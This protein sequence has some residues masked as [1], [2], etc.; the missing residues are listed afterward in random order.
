MR[1]TSFLL[2]TGIFLGAPVWLLNS[3]VMPELNDMRYTYSH[4]D[5]VAAK[6]VEE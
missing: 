3:V 6:A 4:L 1:I 5:E 2:L